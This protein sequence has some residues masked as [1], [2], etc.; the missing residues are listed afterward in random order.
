M[1][2][3]QHRLSPAERAN[4]VAYLDGE[5]NEAESRAIATKLTHSVT[6]RRELEALEKTWEL[7]DHLPRTQPA[8]GFTERTLS[9]VH[10]LADRDG[11]L[12]NLADATASQ[13]VRA[14]VLLASAAATLVLGYVA[15]R[16]VWPDPTARLERNLSIAEHLD[17]Y[18]DVGSFGFLNELYEMPEL[19]EDVAPT[20]SGPELGQG[21]EANRRRL[22]GMPR[23]ER[24]FLA[25]N[26]ERFD[27]LAPEKRAAVEDLDSRLQ[28]LDS[29][30]RAGRIAVLREYHLWLIGLPAAR[31]EV[32][33]KADQSKRVGLI[34]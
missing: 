3:E 1:R 15:T 24:L 23:E 33:E 9:Q 21:I 2:P 5:L 29:A 18:L 20:A 28:G 14:A 7:L 26:L 11:R 13:L 12:V 19:S 34:A 17:E 10:V 31:R 4:L 25:K 22:D 16:W 32:L 6:A 30:G 27:A 8:P